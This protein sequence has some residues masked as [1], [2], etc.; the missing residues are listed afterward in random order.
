[1]SLPPCNNITTLSLIECGISLE[2]LPQLLSCFPQLE[3]FKM[4]RS[5]PLIRDAFGDYTRRERASL[6][7]QAL[8]A[9]AP[10]LKK[11]FLGECILPR[12]RKV[13]RS[14]EG[15]QEVPL[16]PTHGFSGLKTLGL[17]QGNLFH[18]DDCMWHA[19]VL[20]K[21]VRGCPTLETLEIFDALHVSN[22]N[23]PLVPTLGD[24]LQALA[25]ELA[26][27]NNTSGLR[28]IR[29]WYFD[30]VYFERHLEAEDNWCCARAIPSPAANEPSP[31]LASDG[32]GDILLPISDYSGRWAD[33]SQRLRERENSD[34]IELFRSLGVRLT[35]QLEQGTT[36]LSFKSTAIDDTPFPQLRG[37]DPD[38]TLWSRCQC[39]I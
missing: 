6:M 5:R 25:Q 24:A 2:R 39:I 7:L 8:S 18:A 23:N 14:E 17:T 31:P 30:S 19:D 33:R 13:D 12:T 3:R 35:L 27:G 28:E 34:L 16:L 37:I 9:T 29:L 11:I 26:D 15:N 21:I 1:M 32:S 36:R 10:G 4:T 20:A 22:P 38:E